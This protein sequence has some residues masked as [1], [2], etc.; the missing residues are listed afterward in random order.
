MQIHCRYCASE[1]PAANINLDKL[2][3]KCSNCNAVFSIAGEMG[4]AQG[5]KPKAAAKRMSVPLP[6][7]VSMD[8]TAGELV[9]RRKWFSPVS[10]LPL[11]FFAVIW[12]GF[13]VFWY[14]IALSSGEGQMALCGSLHLAVGLFLTYWVAAQFIN[15]TV[16][17]ANAE[18]LDIKSGPIPTTGN[19]ALTAVDIAQIYCMEKISRGRRSTTVTYEVAAIMQDQRRESLLTGLYN[20]E[21][22]LFIEQEVERF[23]GIENRGVPG[24]LGR[25]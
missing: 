17:T 9:I 16:I 7:R 20:P 12:N 6:T 19:K 25:Y 13:L 1:I 2:L 23:L 18:T 11:T 22:A 4:L 10:T 14:S 3:A 21:Q 15:E 5:E 8:E 24:E